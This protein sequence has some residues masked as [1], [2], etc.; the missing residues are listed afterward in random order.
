MP[1]EAVAALEEALTAAGRAHL[2]EVY[3]RCRA[4]LLHGRTSAYDERAAERHFHEP[5]RL[6]DRVLLPG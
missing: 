5:R 3:E 2:D 6:L 4:R 1:S